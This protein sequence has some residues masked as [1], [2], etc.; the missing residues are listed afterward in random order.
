MAD[1]YINY[2]KDLIYNRNGQ[3]DQEIKKNIL[4][5]L[6]DYIDISLSS[7]QKRYEEKNKNEMEMEL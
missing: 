6:T 7:D 1:Y 5:K 4:N 3:N 2:H